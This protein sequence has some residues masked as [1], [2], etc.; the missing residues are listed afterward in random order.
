MFAANVPI[1]E[2]F[3]FT[4]KS[5]EVAGVSVPI[6]G[7]GKIRMKPPLVKFRLG[8]IYGSANNELTG[9]IKSI[10]Y[11]VPDNSVWETRRDG[12]VPKM[13]DATIGYQVIHG[14]VPELKEIQLGMERDYEFYGYTG[15]QH[16]L[17][18]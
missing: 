1:S 17:G 4:A 10:S 5:K 3:F 7:S 13:I 8:D 2:L 9:F 16:L 6:V 15:R 12:K 14:S 11:T 18:G